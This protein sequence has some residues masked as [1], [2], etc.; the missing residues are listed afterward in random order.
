MSYTRMTERGCKDKKSVTN[1]VGSQYLAD[2]APD[3][4]AWAAFYVEAV[5]V[6]QHKERT[7]C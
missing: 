1:V 6:L 5:H 2:H 4:L 3:V 7:S